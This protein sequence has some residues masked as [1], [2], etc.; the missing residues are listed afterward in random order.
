MTTEASHQETA[1]FKREAMADRP[2][3]RYNPV[4]I[5]AGGRTAEGGSLTEGVSIG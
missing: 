2:D 1:A 4:D 3:D 5:A